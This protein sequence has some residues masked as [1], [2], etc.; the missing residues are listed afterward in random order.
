MFALILSF[1]I[2]V[3]IAEAERIFYLIVFNVGNIQWPT[4]SKHR[5][6]DGNLTDRKLLVRK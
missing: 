6:S 1:Q 3:Y 5:S 4:T 2:A